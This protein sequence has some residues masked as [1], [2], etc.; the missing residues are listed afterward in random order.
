VFFW[1][2]CKYIAP[3]AMAITASTQ[4]Q[5]SS[6]QGVEVVGS[7]PPQG[8]S[9]L[10]ANEVTGNNNILPDKIISDT[11]LEIEFRLPLPHINIRIY[12]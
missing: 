12:N 10:W 2:L 3:K 1:W 11:I 6:G 7:S 4:I 8:K 9:P 5:L